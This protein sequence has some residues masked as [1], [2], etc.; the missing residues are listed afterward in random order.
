MACTV[1]DYPSREN[2]ASHGFA[3]SPLSGSRIA[4]LVNI[5]LATNIRL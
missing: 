5:P 2:V 3:L 1:D 4:A